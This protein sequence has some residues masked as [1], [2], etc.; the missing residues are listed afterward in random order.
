MS[1]PE[2]LKEDIYYYRTLTN[3]LFKLLEK[4][5]DLRWLVDYVKSNNDFDFLTGSNRGA[6]WISL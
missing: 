2:L 4:E 5:G 1:H 6:S 3:P